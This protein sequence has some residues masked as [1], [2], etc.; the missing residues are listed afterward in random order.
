MV[1]MDSKQNT[2]TPIVGYNHY[3]GWY[4]QDIIDN[5]IWIDKFHQLYPD[6]HLGISEYGSECKQ[7]IW[8]IINE[9]NF[10]YYRFR[11]FVDLSDPKILYKLY[12]NHC[13]I[14]NIIQNNKLDNLEYIVHS[15]LYGGISSFT[16]KIIENR[17]YFK[18]F[19]NI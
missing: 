6:I 13:D 12:D 14:L 18:H 17:Q 3:F 8:D 10:H 2:L 7:T 5:E 15:H 1:S 11:V 16:N 9:L 4:L 19:K